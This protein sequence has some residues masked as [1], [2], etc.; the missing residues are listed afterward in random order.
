MIFGDLCMRF[1]KPSE[2]IVDVIG[3]KA[4]ECVGYLVSC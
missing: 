3:I 4:C 1:L 2:E